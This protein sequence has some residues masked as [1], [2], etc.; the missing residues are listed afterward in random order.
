CRPLRLL[1]CLVSAGMRRRL[2]NG[3]RLL[4][5]TL[6]LVGAYVSRVGELELNRVLRPRIMG[7]E[8]ACF[9]R[10]RVLVEQGDDRIAGILAGWG[11]VLGAELN[12]LIVQLERVVRPARAIG[13]YR[14]DTPS[15]MADAHDQRLAGPVRFFRRLVLGRD[16]QN[17]V[18]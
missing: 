12:H 15:L 16:T 14:A 11:L 9:N 10:A 17:D 4:V 3:V 6:A 8:V 13:A 2:P 18:E 7:Q 1:Q 5:A